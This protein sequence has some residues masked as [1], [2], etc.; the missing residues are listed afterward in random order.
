[1]L[2]E[3]EGG[4]IGTGLIPAREGGIRL[5][6]SS[7]GSWSDPARGARQF[8]GSPRSLLYKGGLH[9]ALQLA[10]SRACIRRWCLG[11]ITHHAFRIW[12]TEGKEDWLCVL[13]VELSSPHWL[14][15][16]A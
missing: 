7:P 8:E 5:G 1:L 16:A 9:R 11:A 2:R 4:R 10:P 3:G 13:S 15:L 6:V 14:P 12:I